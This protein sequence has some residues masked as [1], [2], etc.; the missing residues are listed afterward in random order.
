MTFT[1]HVYHN[2]VLNFKMSTMCLEIHPRNIKG[3]YAHINNGKMDKI[4]YILFFTKM[5]GLD[6][7]AMVIFPSLY[8]GKKPHKEQLCYC[9]KSDRKE[10][11]APH[12]I[13]RHL[14][15]K[16][17]L[18]SVYAQSSMGTSVLCSYLINRVRVEKIL[19]LPS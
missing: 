18:P 9:I 14:Q 13:V 15:G 7:G 17:S 10:P 1:D 2:V 16:T 8:R 11:W 12:S 3:I 6:G 5:C 4:I 19:V